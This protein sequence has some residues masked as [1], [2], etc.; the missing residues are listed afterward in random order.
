MALIDIMPVVEAAVVLVT[1]TV[2][3]LVVKVVK[4]GKTDRDLSLI[5]I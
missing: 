5:H 4:V 3:T 1:L 2:Q